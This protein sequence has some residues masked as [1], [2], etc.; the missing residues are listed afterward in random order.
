MTVSSNGYGM[1]GKSGLNGSKE[2]S[3]SRHGNVPSAPSPGL[4]LF[5]NEEQA[6]LIFSVGLDS[7]G[8][9]GWRIPAHSF[10][11]SGA[12]PVFR[13]IIE[14]YA[15]SYSVEKKPEITVFCQPELF[16][17]MLS[18]IYKNETPLTSVTNTLNLIPVANQFMLHDLIRSCLSYLKQKVCPENALEILSFMRKLSPSSTSSTKYSSQ[19]GNNGSGLYPCLFDSVMQGDYVLNELVVKCFDIIDA[20]AEE[21]LRSDSIE[22]LDQSLLVE[23]LSRDT[24]SLASEMTA[25][26]CLLNWASQQCL[27]NRLPLTSENKR[28]VLESGLYSA[29]YL[30]M[31][32]DDFMKGPYSSDLLSQEE[33]NYLLGRLRK[34]PCLDIP[35]KQLVGRKLDIPRKPRPKGSVKTTCDCKSKKRRNESAIGGPRKKSASKKILNGLSG[36]MICVIQLLD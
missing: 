2:N 29:R 5:N 21:I 19:L 12:S 30:L 10:V 4:V 31:T 23:I 6:D 27:K 28:N 24:L 11:V 26:D 9:D 20:N 8:K 16:H 32:V 1:P 13:G 7:K 17:Y 25:F 15:G 18:Y 14:K 33:K 34:D 35:P 36:F 22:G 3:L